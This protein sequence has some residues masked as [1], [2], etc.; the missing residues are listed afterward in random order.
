MAAKKCSITT[1]ILVVLAMVFTFAAKPATAN[2]LQLDFSYEGSD[3]GSMTIE[4]VDDYTL[5]VRYDADSS[6]PAGSQATGFA[7]VFN[8]QLPASVNNPAASD[9][10]WDNDILIWIKLVNLNP[11]P[12]S[13]PVDKREFNYGVTEGNANNFNPPGIKPGESDI[14]YLLFNN[15]VTQE[16]ISELIKHAG[17]R[18]QGLPG[19]ID[20]GSLFL[21]G[22][23]RDIDD[24]GI[25]LDNDQPDDYSVPEPGTF[26]LLGAGLFGAG[27]Y[28]RKRIN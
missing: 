13:S 16:D 23:I 24:T 9:F 6:I 27:L 2:A 19:N 18:L 20:G 5:S 25:L 21:V 1:K 8:G 11:I 3:W 4:S 10:A 22:D 17:V 14:F 15:P 12:N 28:A 7:F 26:I